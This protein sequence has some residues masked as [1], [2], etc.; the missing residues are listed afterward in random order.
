M[1]W[2]GPNPVKQS[3][4]KEYNTLLF[5]EHDTI[6]LYDNCVIYKQLLNNIK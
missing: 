6:K 4:L 3:L 2:R 1:P 5:V